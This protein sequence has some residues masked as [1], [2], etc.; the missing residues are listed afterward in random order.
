VTNPFRALGD[1]LYERRAARRYLRTL[2]RRQNPQERAIR[3]AK[4]IAER[5]SETLDRL[6]D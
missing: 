4:R 1:W 2:G 5:N 6:K 3:I